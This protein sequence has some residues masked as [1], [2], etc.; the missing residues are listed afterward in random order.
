MQ[1]RKPPG[2]RGRGRRRQRRLPRLLINCDTE[3]S[4]LEYNHE[5]Q[6]E[7]QVLKVPHVYGEFPGSHDWDCWDLHIREALEFH[8]CNLHPPPVLRIT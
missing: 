3:D 8:A 6:E 2:F 5:F 7:L 4:L 1:R